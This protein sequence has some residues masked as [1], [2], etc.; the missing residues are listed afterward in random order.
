M[1]LFYQSLDILYYV[2][3]YCYISFVLVYTIKH[4]YKLDVNQKK[5]MLDFS[6]MLSFH[7]IVY[8]LIMLLNGAL[9]NSLLYVHYSYPIYTL[10]NANITTT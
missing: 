3:N 10:H 4:Q 5:N 1:V 9:P 6:L 7:L 8:Y 2:A